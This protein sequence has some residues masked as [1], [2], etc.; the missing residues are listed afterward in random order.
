MT[1]LSE[2]DALNLSCLLPTFCK[3]F[4]RMFCLVG[5]GERVILHSY[6]LMAGSGSILKNVNNNLYFFKDFF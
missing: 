3:S 1:A 2:V 5:C 6:F 4:F